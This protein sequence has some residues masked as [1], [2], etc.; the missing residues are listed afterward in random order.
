MDYVWLFMFVV[1]SWSLVGLAA[2]ARESFTAREE[3][4][5]ARAVSVLGYVTG[6]PVLF[7]AMAYGADRVRAPF[8][9]LIVVT[10]HVLL[11]AVA[12]IYTVRTRR[13]LRDG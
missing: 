10:T 3:G 7:T 2:R 6:P 8:G 1:A 4:R 12:L 11:A 13:A 5:D 9:L